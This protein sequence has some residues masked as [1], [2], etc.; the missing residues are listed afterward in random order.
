MKK[1]RLE[2]DFNETNKFQT[3]VRGIKIRVHIL[4]KKK[5][6]KDVRSCVN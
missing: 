4:P 2:K 1:H 3:S 5:P 6:K